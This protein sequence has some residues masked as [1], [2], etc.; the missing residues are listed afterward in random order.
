MSVS[1]FRKAKRRDSEMLTRRN[2]IY[3][4]LDAYDYYLYY[5]P[6]LSFLHPEVTRQKIQVCNC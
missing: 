6:C 3:T 1:M 5:I 2:L 4:H